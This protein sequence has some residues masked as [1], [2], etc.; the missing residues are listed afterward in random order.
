LDFLKRV[1]LLI[2]LKLKDSIFDFFPDFGITTKQSRGRE[3]EAFDGDRR[4]QIDCPDLEGGVG[5]IEAQDCSSRQRESF[6]AR[7]AQS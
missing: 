4:L 2:D 5:R 7:T 6:V 1:Q 3:V